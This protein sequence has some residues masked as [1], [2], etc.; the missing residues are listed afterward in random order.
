M[1]S[2]DP[3]LLLNLTVT[4][5]RCNVL[6]TP[7][8][9]VDTRQE[10]MRNYLKVSDSTMQ[11]PLSSES[12]A[13]SLFCELFHHHLLMTFFRKSTFK[14]LIQWKIYFYHFLVLYLISLD[15][16]NIYLMSG[17]YLRSQFDEFLKEG[18]K[19]VLITIF[20]SP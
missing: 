12:E 7:P 2:L 14:P 4:S 5:K 10:N 20:L 15:F 11:F 19:V 3:A 6:C 17:P 9:M 16:L 18:W 1:K 8:F 13:W